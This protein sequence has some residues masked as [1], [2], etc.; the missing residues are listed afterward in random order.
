LGF[1]DG[2]TPVTDTMRR[3]A[4]VLRAKSKRNMRI[5]IGIVTVIAV[6]VIISVI[7]NLLPG[8]ENYD[9]DIQGGINETL[10]T[11]D[12]EMTVTDFS[13]YEEGGAYYP[14]AENRPY[15]SYTA[16]K[17]EVLYIVTLELYNVRDIQS[18]TINNVVDFYLWD[19][20]TA[21]DVGNF[22]WSENYDYIV[23]DDPYYSASFNLTPFEIRTQV[24]VFKMPKKAA[25]SCYF[26]YDEY[27]YDSYY[28]EY[29]F[30]QSYGIK[31]F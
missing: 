29:N 9:F 5:V 17:N 18:A 23:Q 14:D 13:I 4:V 28:D 26:E 24:L 8:K 7:A 6:I 10:Q 16:G 2:G 3:E 11:P 19:G 15:V 30:V 12:F 21:Y 1:S 31:L 25:T 22:I 27:E 20:R